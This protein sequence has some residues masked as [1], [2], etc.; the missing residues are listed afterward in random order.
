MFIIGLKKAA[1]SADNFPKYALLPIFFKK[2]LDNAH[3]VCYTV[4]VENP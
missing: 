3:M 2:S 4:T 1:I